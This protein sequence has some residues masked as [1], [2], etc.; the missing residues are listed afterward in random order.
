MHTAY[1]IRDLFAYVEYNKLI[2]III[3]Y[4]IINTVK[5]SYLR[6]GPSSVGVPNQDILKFLILYVKSER[7]H[8]DKCVHC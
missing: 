6:R 7:R 4:F 2:I 3:I 8:D 1:I 5:T